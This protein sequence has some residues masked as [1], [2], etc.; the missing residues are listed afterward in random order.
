M[1]DQDRTVRNVVRWQR[2]VAQIGDS[3]SEGT[4][5]TCPPGRQA[6]GRIFVCN[7]S[8]ATVTIGI[9]YQEGGEADADKQWIAYE[10]PIPA[11][12]TNA[13]EEL[14]LTADDSIEVYGT[15]DVSFSF[16]GYTEPK[17]T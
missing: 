9:R 12:D 7:R 11:E 4:L 16:I 1:A 13:T 2:A 6:R 15:A 10:F 3:S 8:A 17:D 14:F 5:Y